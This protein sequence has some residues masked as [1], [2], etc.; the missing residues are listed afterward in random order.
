MEY[1]KVNIKIW[2]CMMIWMRLYAHVFK[3]ACKRILIHPGH[4][5]C[6]VH[7]WYIHV[8]KNIP[9]VQ[10]N[11][12]SWCPVRPPGQPG[13]HTFVHTRYIKSTCTHTINHTYTH[14]LLYTIHVLVSFSFRK[15]CTVVPSYSNWYSCNCNCG[16]RYPVIVFIFMVMVT[17]IYNKKN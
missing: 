11:Q 4:V 13:W 12:R 6:V 1:V 3:R 8:A 15:I 14:V 2:W 10:M 16:A 9:C 7:T 5:A 17:K